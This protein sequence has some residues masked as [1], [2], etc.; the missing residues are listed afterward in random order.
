MLF[1]I[2]GTLAAGAVVRLDAD[3]EDVASPLGGLV[4]DGDAFQVPAGGAVGVAAPAVTSADP[5]MSATSRRAALAAGGATL[6]SLALPRSASADENE[7]AIAKI[8]AK[9]NAENERAK[10]AERARMEARLQR[11][12]TEEQE[13]EEKQQDAKNK[14][15]GIAGGGTLLSTYFFKD[16]LQRLAI[17]ITSGGQDAGY[18]TLANRKNAA[19]AKKGGRP[20]PKRGRGKQQEEEPPAKGGFFR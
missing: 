5:V 6:A 11:G 10:A 12:K 1:L 14:I 2:M 8:A 9:A 13:S 19:A 16:N 18:E 4:A 3:A 7:D 20:A 15:L 17:K